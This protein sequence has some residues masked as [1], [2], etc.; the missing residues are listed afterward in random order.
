MLIRLS[1]NINIRARIHYIHESKTQKMFICSLAIKNVAI[2]A[3]LK[4]QSKFRST[5][6]MVYSTNDMLDLMIQAVYKLFC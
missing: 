1:L 2:L 6:E 3:C 5:N 4:Y